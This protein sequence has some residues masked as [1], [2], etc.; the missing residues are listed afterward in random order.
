MR[1]LIRATLR[2]LLFH[3]G[4][5]RV[6]VERPDNDQAVRARMAANRGK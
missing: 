6:P 2:R 3:L 5:H 1:R 4:L